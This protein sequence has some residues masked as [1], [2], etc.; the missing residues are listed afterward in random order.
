[1]LRVIKE[2]TRLLFPATAGTAF[3][4][5][6]RLARHMKYDTYGPKGLLIHRTSLLLSFN[7][8]LVVFRQ[9][10]GKNQLAILERCQSSQIHIFVV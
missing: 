2:K 6:L 9:Q 4:F 1:M 8:F 5:N 3:K 7:A 10:V